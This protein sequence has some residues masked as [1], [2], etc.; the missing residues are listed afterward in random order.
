MSHWNKASDEM[1]AYYRSLLKSKLKNIPL[2]G[3]IT[4]NDPNCTKNEHQEDINRFCENILNS[5]D[6]SVK[7][8]IPLTRTNQ[9]QKVIPG[10]SEAVKPYQV[11]ARFWYSVWLSYGKPINCQIHHLMKHTKNQFHYAVRRMKRNASDTSSKK[12]MQSFKTDKRP[13]LIK[14]LKKLRC[15][16]K[17][18]PPLNIDDRSNPTEIANHFSTIY[19]DLYNRHDSHEEMNN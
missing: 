6:S 14:S 11:E 18:S 5:I 10:W 7:T 4:C 1:I 17:V 12:M 19:K 8:C 2:S 16:D 3:G 9:K 15:S 13:G